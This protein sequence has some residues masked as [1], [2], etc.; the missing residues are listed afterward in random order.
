MKTLTQEYL[1]EIL[2]YN[3]LTGIFKNR[4]TRNSRSLKGSV[5]GYIT[6]RGYEVI[7]I[8]GKIY[9][10]HRLAWL[11]MEGYFP[12]NEIDHEDRNPSNN[13]FDNLRVASHMCNMRNKGMY[14]ANKSG[15]TGV[16]W[17]KP[18]S[19]WEVSIAVEGR[20]T[21][22]GYFDSKIKAAKSRWKGEKKYNYPNCSTTSSA[23]LY[24]KKYYR[25]I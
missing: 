19:K 21:G 16:C 13:K 22:L 6:V 24:I 20:K 7:G 1:K 17:Y 23:L 14:S 8:K 15:I 9:Q 25:L 3:P 2:H 10:S 18:T 11:Y 5:A 4:L 12:E